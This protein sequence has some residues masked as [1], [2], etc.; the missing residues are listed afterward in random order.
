[1]YKVQKLGALLLGANRVS[2]PV[3]FGG[4]PKKKAR[5]PEAGDHDLP[6]SWK[7][8][9]GHRHDAIFK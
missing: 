2:G 5:I 7:Y 1:L 8:Q 9:P 3:S 6:W 4:T